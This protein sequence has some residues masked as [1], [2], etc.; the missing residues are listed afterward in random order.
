[1]SPNLDLFGHP[2][3]DT[4]IRIAPDQGAAQLT[5]A[6][7]A[8]NT[9]IKQIEKKRAQL[10]EWETAAP[11]FQQKFSLELSPLIEQTTDIKIEIVLSLDLACDQKGFSQNEYN[12][13]EDLIFDLA[14]TV[15]A[16]REDER[17]KAVYDKYHTVTYDQQNAAELA[18]IKSLL[19]TATGLDLGEDLDMNDPE[20]VLRHLQK[21]M[22]A[23]MAAEASQRAEQAEGQAKRKKSAK[24]IAREQKLHAEAQHI[25]QSLREIYRKLASALHPDRESD[26]EERER[27]TA[28]M[29]RVNQ[30]HENGNLL[31]LLELQLELEHI[32]PSAFSNL[33]EERLLRYN[34]IL[35]EQL[36][37]LNDEITQF[38]GE[39]RVRFGIN[40]AINLSPA[41]VLHLL[42]QEITNAQQT[43]IELN[44]D[45]V[46]L[47]NIKTTKSWLKKMQRWNSQR[48]SYDG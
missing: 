15:L 28:L 10:L 44:K 26:P 45:L 30:A 17:V 36:K 34:S 42:A 48:N 16:E 41:K 20:A 27:K 25:S 32:T 24:Q 23:Q 37:E 4:S 14:E 18:R 13:I 40:P 9:L 1:M 6:Q 8:F 46:N 47:Q 5:K 38:E 39:F 2:I 33:D 29:Q 43:I 3:N 21:Q 12:L 22:S 11:S 35:K 7:K 19:E 31:Q